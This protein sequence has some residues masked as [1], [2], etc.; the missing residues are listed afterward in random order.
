MFSHFMAFCGDKLTRPEFFCWPGAWMA[1]ERLFPEIE[2]LFHRHEALFMDKPD[3]GG[4]YPRLMPGKDETVVQ[5]NFERFYAVN[6]AYDLTRQWIAASGPFGYDYRWLS[7][8]G[9]GAD[10]KGFADRHF[11]QVYGVHPDRFLLI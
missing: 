7:S 10:M 5:E 4:I 9:T 3:D 2:N 6:V 1:G 8:T 11:E